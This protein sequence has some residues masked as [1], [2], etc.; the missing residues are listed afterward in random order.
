[1]YLVRSQVPTSHLPEMPV[2]TYLDGLR[3]AGLV[4]LASELAQARSWL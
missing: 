4:I 3:K 2:D 1:M